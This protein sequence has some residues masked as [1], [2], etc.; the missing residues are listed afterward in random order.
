MR[1]LRMDDSP[2]VQQQNRTAQPDMTPLMVAINQR[3]VANETNVNQAL[4]SV[5]QELMLHDF[6]IQRIFEKV[7][8]KDSYAEFKK[9]AVAELFPAPTPPDVVTK[10]DLDARLADTIGTI[11][12]LFQQMGEQLESRVDTQV[13]DMMS[14]MLDQ[15]NA[16]TTAPSGI[17]PTSAR[18]TRPDDMD[19]GPDADP[20]TVVR[21]PKRDRDNRKE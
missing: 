1:G 8:P 3:F 10:T 17:Q 15:V 19:T 4:T 7:Y 13:T 18:A 9:D 11:T 6:M 21:L 14:R 2:D 12:K 5:G 16:Q 20:P